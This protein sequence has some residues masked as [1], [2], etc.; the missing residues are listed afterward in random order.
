MFVFFTNFSYNLVLLKVIFYF[1]PFFFGAFS[2]LFFIFGGCLKQ[3]QDN[4]V[5]FQADKSTTTF[6]GDSL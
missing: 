1:H 3:I 5:F 4:G 2:G 6:K